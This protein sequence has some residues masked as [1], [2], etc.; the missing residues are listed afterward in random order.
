MDIF[1]P[2]SSHLVFAYLCLARALHCTVPGCELLSLFAEFLISF[3]KNVLKLREYRCLLLVLTAV[4]SSSS[5]PK[6][7]LRHPDVV[8]QRFS[9]VSPRT[10]ALLP[11]ALQQISQQHVPSAYPIPPNICHRFIRG[12]RAHV[13][14]CQPTPSRCSSFG[15][16]T[17][18]LL[19]GDEVTSLSAV[20][21]SPSL[22]STLLIAL[23]VMF[24]WQAAQPRDMV[25]SQTVSDRSIS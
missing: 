18:C 17:R 6:R 2:R 19:R 15:V 8:G 25:I 23:S 11:L 13:T 16:A 12:G 20:T 22:Q 7:T 4:I 14:L 3:L 21:P 10:T 24:S 5:C 1:K 9:A